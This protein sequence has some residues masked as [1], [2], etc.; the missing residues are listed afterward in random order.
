MIG[1][2]I[3]PPR[4]AREQPIDAGLRVL[5]AHPDGLARAMIRTA[6]QHVPRVAII[7]TATDAQEALELARYYRPS[8]LLCD[9][10]LA[11]N[12]AVE[13]IANVLAAVPDVRILTVS[14]ASDDHHGA[15]AALHAGASGHIDKDVDPAQLAPL[16]LRFA[17]GDAIVPQRLVAPL[18]E[19]LRELPDSGWRPLHSSLTTREWQ[20]VDLLSD[21]ASTDQIADRLVLSPTTVYSHVNN[22]LR[23]LGVHCRRDA[24]A[25]AQ[26]LRREEPLLSKALT[27][28]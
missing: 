2:P 3:S 6:L 26:R 19:R 12:G 21:G 24:V 23:K 20:I 9:L 10:A 27:G 4:P 15:L 28:S 18:L 1:D 7:L 13:L 5:I 14:A 17:D 8:V 22:L 11:P 16:I 25:A